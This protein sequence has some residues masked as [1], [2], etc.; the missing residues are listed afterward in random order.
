MLTPS[1]ERYTIVCMCNVSRL[2]RP[3]SFLS[4][5]LQ[6]LRQEELQAGGRVTRPKEPRGIVLAP[7]IGGWER[8]TSH[9]R[10]C[11]LAAYHRA[12]RNDRACA[13]EAARRGLAGVRLAVASPQR[14]LTGGKAR[15]G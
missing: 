12:G 5:H 14:A 4:P 11:G 15:P 7:T 10:G 6:L 13:A 9:T 8:A 3:S 1:A 2:R